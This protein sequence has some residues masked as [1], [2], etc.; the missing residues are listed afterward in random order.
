MYTFQIN[1]LISIFGVFCEFRTSCVHHQ[2]DNLLRIEH[3]LLSARLLTETH[4]KHTLKNCK[5]K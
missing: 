4:E 5:Y 1:V 3:F 2:E